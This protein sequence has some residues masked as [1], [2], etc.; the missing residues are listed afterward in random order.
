MS[1]KRHGRKLTCPRRLLPLL[2]VLVSPSILQGVIHKPSQ[3][4]P[5][6][7]D[8][9]QSSMEPQV[10]AKIQEHREAVIAHPSS[11]ESWGKLGMVLH[12]HGHERE[13]FVCYENAANLEPKEFRWPYLMARSVRGDDR[14][15]TL[16]LA[17]RASELMPYYSPIYVL[18]GELLEEDNEVESAKE[19]YEKAVAND[20]RCA[21]A[22]AGL[23]RLYLLEGDL[24]A[25]L[26][27]LL[28][29]AELSENAGEIHGFL[30]RVYRRMGDM[31]RAKEEAKLARELT[32]QMALRD[33][34]MG[35]MRAEDVSSVTQL[36]QAMEVDDAGDYEKAET[37]YR[38]LLEIRPADTNIHE[39][40]ATT[41]VHQNELPE[42]W[43]HYEK[44]LDIK[45]ENP[46][47]LY[48]LG[49]ILGLEKNFDE[50]VEMYRKSLALNPDHMPTLVNMAN[51]LAFLGQLDEAAGAFQKALDVAPDS[52]DRF[53]LHQHL[54]RIR[55]RQGE[56]ERAV[57]QFEAALESRPDAGEVHFGLAAALADTG[58]F[59]SAWNH[60]EEARKLGF[61]V[62]AAFLS[63]LQERLKR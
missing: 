53:T 61:A 36:E 1:M 19:Q 50:S 35:D 23:G 15:K 2:M 26:R 55:V 52:S 17:E 7:P 13:A 21:P 40:L 34:V 42:A 16:A 56:Y 20:S 37:M 14:E 48:G 5:T 8:P 58:D 30:V 29:A 28:R 18:R 62:P 27:H 4:I 49:N 47:A 11:S 59:Q 24:E 51:V 63:A 9:D 60:A 54:A 12:A 41:L 46:G 6:V 38:R 45:P 32:G 3:E 25:S 39:R 31:D 57:T 43:E 44:A 33:P 10:A 22:E